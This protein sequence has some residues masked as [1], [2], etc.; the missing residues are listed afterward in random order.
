MNYISQN[1]KYLRI[2]NKLKQEDIAKIV[3]KTRTLIS[4]W[5]ANEREITIGDIITLAN[6]FKVPLED[7]VG[8][9]LRIEHPNEEI[10][11]VEFGD[12]KVTLSKDGNITNDDL[13]EAM[14]FILEQKMKN[15]KENKD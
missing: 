8:K 14:A 4:L 12:M 5:E 11:E 10:K 1:L 9:D 7:L 2:K 6:Y 3:N 13:D 15:K